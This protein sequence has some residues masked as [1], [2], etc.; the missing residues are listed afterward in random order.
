MVLESIRL[1][2]LDKNVNPEM[3][4]LK[5]IQEHFQERTKMKDCLDKK[6]QEM[7]N[8][9]SKSFGTGEGANSNFSNPEYWINLFSAKDLEHIIGLS[10]KEEKKCEEHGNCTKETRR[11]FLHLALEPDRVRES[12]LSQL[13]DFSIEKEDTCFI[14]I[15]SSSCV[16]P[17][18]NCTQRISINFLPQILVVEYI[19]PNASIKFCD[20]QEI[21]LQETKYNLKSMT[22]YLT[23][24]F[25]AYFLHEGNL[26]FYNDLMSPTSVKCKNFPQDDGELQGNRHLYFYTKN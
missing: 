8:Q 14:Q 20:I 11:S 4:P 7:R 24:H 21:E 12:I 6:K 10:L 26:I 25:V 18:R 13:I 19:L 17:C 1:C 23:N 9:I 3:E 5:I 15:D 22:R 16:A 2:L